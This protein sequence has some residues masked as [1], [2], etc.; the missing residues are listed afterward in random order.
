GKFS[1]LTEIGAPFII[2]VRENVHFP[3]WY[4]GRWRRRRFRTRRTGSFARFSWTALAGIL[5]T[6]GRFGPKLL[7]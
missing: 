2:G 6:D 1:V 3:G 4:P 5:D 7:A